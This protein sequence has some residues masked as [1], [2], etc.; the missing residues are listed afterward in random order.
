MLLEF[1]ANLLFKNEHWVLTAG[2]GVIRCQQGV[3]DSTPD[4]IYPHAI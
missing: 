4:T 3:T 2:R 1:D